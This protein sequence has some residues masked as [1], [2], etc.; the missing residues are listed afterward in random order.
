MPPLTPAATAQIIASAIEHKEGRKKL[1]LGRLPTLPEFV[2]SHLTDEMRKLR[3]RKRLRKKKALQTLQRMWAV[4]VLFR[5]RRINYTE[6][7]RSLFPVQSLPQ[8]A[9]AI[10]DRDPGITGTITEEP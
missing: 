10:Y 4:M 8:G 7:A 1:E 9:S 6:V 3:G 5:P 2:Q